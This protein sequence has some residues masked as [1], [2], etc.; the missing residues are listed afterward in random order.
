MS[1]NANGGHAAGMGSLRLDDNTT[2]VVRPVQPVDRF[3]LAA[4]FAKLSPDSRTH[5]FLGPKRQLSARELTYLTVIDHAEHDALVATDDRGEIVAVARYAASPDRSLH[6]A[7]VAIVV[8]DAWRGR[9]IGSA[10]TRAVTERA[11]ANGFTRLTASTFADNGPARRLLSRLGFRL[12][13]V[14]DGIG[15]YRLDLPAP[16][17]DAA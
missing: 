14:S 13:G 16:C 17:R 15:S 7:E 12:A 9:G 6:S 4:A 8:A 1:A 5:R 10:L 3:G 2:I 11:R